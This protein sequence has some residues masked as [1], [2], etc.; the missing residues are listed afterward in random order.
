MTDFDRANEAS[1][2]A[3]ARIRRVSGLMPLGSVRVGPVLIEWQADERLDQGQTPRAA[4]LAGR[5]TRS[6]P[7]LAP[8]VAAVQK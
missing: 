7:K 8:R 5:G 2:P 4:G 6:A 1:M 3:S